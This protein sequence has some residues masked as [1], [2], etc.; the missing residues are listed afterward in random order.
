[1]DRVEGLV[2]VAL[3]V[4]NGAKDVASAIDSVLAQTY[5]PMEL[6]VVDDGSTDGT[7]DV[8]QRYGNRITAIRQKNGGLPVARNT[9]MSHSR[10]EFIALMDHDDLC[11]PER[12]AVQAALLKAYP[13]VGLCSSDFS[14]FSDQGPIEASHIGSYYSQCDPRT[15][16]VAALYPHSAQLDVNG[17][18]VRILKG[19]VYEK[20]AFGN[21]VHP[22]T[23]MVR[24]DVARAVGPFDVEARTTCD[25][26]WIVRVAKHGPIGYVDR[27]LLDYRL[28]P[29]Q[30]SG[31]R[32]RAS[33]HWVTLQ[34]ATRIMER[35]PE[36]RRRH[37]ARVRAAMGEFSMDAAYSNAE[38]RPELAWKCWWAGVARHGYLR[39]LTWQTLGR[40]VLPR[41]L[42]AWKRQR[43]GAPPPA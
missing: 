13:E 9:A 30:M 28:S 38:S 6:I 35:D 2:S 43:L 1:M 24:A 37:P 20:I 3:V 27:P 23:I 26:D 36:L 11:M 31:Q 4:Y 42:L 8:L 17:L 14:A 21:F 34:V 7:W 12:L 40:L 39:K 25:W 10:G 15:G 33:G 19:D 18:V 32:N 22:P 29:S 5:Q 16:G 41:R